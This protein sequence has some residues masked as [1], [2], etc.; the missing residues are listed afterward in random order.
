MG[1]L[2]GAKNKVK[3][4]VNY[5]LFSII[6]AIITAMLAFL[7]SIII[8]KDNI[9]ISFIYLLMLIILLLL[10]LLNKH[11]LLPTGNFVV[12]AEW[13]KSSDNNVGALWGIILGLGWITLQAGVLFHAYVLTLI[14]DGSI[15]TALIGGLLF[16]LVRS[17]PA[18]IPT[19]RK[20]IYKLEKNRRSIR[21]VIT[22]TVIVTIIICY[23]MF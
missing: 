1:C 13:I 9:Y 6:G 8:P 18:S 14:I 20:L 10:E 4:S 15:K 7:I 11:K 22:F 12:P 3:Y 21:Q 5:I 19:F 23:F 2:D 16:G 17:G